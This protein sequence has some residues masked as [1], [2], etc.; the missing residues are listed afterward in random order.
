MTKI[1]FKKSLSAFYNAPRQDFVLV[2]VPSMRFVMI[3][4]EGDPN[5]ALSYKHAIEWLFSVSY[6]MKFAA[7]AARPSLQILHIGSYDDEGPALTR[8]HHEEMP[9]RGFAFN[10]K[11]HEIYLSDARKTTPAKLETILRQPVRTV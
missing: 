5:T 1:D 3:D 4:G 6:A 9:A 8:L 2:D 11:H 7:K 10:G